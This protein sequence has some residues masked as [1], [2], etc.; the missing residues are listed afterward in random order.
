MRQFKTNSLI[1]LSS[2]MAISLASATASAATLATFNIGY[3]GSWSGG[4]SGT[5]SGSGTAILDNTGVLTITTQTTFVGTTGRGKN[6]STTNFTT[7]NTDVFTGSWN[8]VDTLSITS[9]TTTPTSCT[10]NVSTSTGC[11]TITLNSPIT[12]STMPT[13][14]VFNLAA[15]GTTAISAGYTLGSGNTKYTITETYTFT[16]VAPVPVPATGWLFGSG[17]IGMAL[18][19]R[20]RGNS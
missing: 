13:S 11:S 5:V 17:L 1:A 12:Y 6:S 8:G 18:V 7:N 16:T 2:A 3:S 20:R 4:A 15:S 14:A 9:G 19:A 10:D